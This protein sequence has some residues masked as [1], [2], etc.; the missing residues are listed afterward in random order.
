MIRSLYKFHCIGPNTWILRYYPWPLHLHPDSQGDHLA[1]EAAQLD[2][3]PP[4]KAI[5]TQSHNL[6]RVASIKM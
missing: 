1:F 5:I 2:D 6:I 3:P 4:D